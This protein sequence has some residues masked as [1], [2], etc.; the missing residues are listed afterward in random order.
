M[1]GMEGME[2]VAH[3][4]SALK[5]QRDRAQKR[6][7]SLIEAAFVLAVVGAVIGTIWVVASAVMENWRL[8]KYSEKVIEVNKCIR[9]KFPRLQCDT[10]LCNGSMVDQ[11]IFFG[12]IGC[13]PEDFFIRGGN[14]YLDIYGR[15]FYVTFNSDDTLTIIINYAQ[16]GT[17][18]QCA[19]L[20]NRI[21]GMDQ[22]REIKSIQIG[23]NVK[24]PRHTLEE[25]NTFCQ[26]GKSLIISFKP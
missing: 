2:A 26:L 10:I 12:N 17:A 6:G 15:N 23:P 1:E 25:W 8:N 9:N 18:S 7:F 5:Q 19:S 3:N 20:A 22:G 16:E 24:G 11:T 21:S 4:T 14:Y 13:I